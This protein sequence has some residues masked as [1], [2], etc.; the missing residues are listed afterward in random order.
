M[1]TPNNETLMKPNRKIIQ[2]SPAIHLINTNNA[3]SI[4]TRKLTYSGHDDND[5]NKQ[6]I[7]P[8]PIGL[9]IQHLK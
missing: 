9:T 8:Q 7:S 3:Q 2:S 1:Q 4:L 6:H 5:G